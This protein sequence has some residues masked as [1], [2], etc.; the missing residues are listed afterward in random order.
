VLVNTPYLILNGTAQVA[1]VPLMLGNV[2]DE[3]AGVVLFPNTTNITSAIEAIDL[4]PQSYYKYPN[5][6]PL[7]SGPN[8]TLDAFNLT[9]HLAT[10]AGLRCLDQAIAYTAADNQAWFYE[11]TRTYQPINHEYNSPVCDAPITEEYPYG[12]PNGVYFR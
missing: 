5:L 4:D 3:G 10:D 9:T 6:F 2:R 8:A 12:D 1:Q 7:P 11:F